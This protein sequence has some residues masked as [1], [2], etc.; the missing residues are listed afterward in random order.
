[1]LKDINH[2]INEITN[3]RISEIANDIFRSD[4]KCKKATQEVISTY[5]SLEKLLPQE[6]KKNLYDYEDAI[7]LKESVV[8]KALYKQGI[9]DGLRIAA[10]YNNLIKKND[11]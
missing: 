9:K 3:E 1:M 7:G 6:S 2:L 11:K 5:I 4:E 10:L 8:Y